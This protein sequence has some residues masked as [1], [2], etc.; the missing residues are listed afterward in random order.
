MKTNRSWN[1]WEGLFRLFDMR[2]ALD[3]TDE[4]L[5]IEVPSRMKRNSGWGHEGAGE[6]DTTC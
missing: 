1:Q 3:L 2:C 6:C 5:D 4:D